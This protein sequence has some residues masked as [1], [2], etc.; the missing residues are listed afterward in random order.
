MRAMKEH[1]MTSKM[2][3]WTISVLPIV[4]S[5]KEAKWAKNTMKSGYEIG[6]KWH[7]VI[8]HKTEV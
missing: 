2:F 4:L 7:S 1:S 3:L 5:I 6:S 8:W